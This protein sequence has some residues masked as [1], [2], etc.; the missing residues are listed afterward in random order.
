M[1][2]LVGRQGLLRISGLVSTLKAGFNGTGEFRTINFVAKAAGIVDL[3]L[4]FFKD[5]T[6]DTNILEIST[7][8]DILGSVENIKVVIQ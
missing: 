3:S 5:K 6:S 2:L 4:D 1:R 8:K 7:N